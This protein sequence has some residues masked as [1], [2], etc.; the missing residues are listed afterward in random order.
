[1][2][3][4]WVGQGEGR[5]VACHTDRCEILPFLSVLSPHLPCAFVIF[6]VELSMHQVA[7]FPPAHAG[8]GHSRPHFCPPAGCMWSKENSKGKGQ[9]MVKLPE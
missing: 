9:M 1:M 3:A 5:S 8:N 6:P 7:C 2:L 4:L